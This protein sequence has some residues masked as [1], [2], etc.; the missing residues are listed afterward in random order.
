M[1]HVASANFGFLLDI[2]FKNF[3]NGLDFRDSILNDFCFFKNDASNWKGKKK[4]KNI[5]IYTHT[6]THT[7]THT[8]MCIAKHACTL[9]YQKALHTSCL[10]EGV[11]VNKKL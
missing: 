4:K 5:Y 11:G 6:H 9:A 1:V 10:P 7:H 8:Y 3:V 2:F